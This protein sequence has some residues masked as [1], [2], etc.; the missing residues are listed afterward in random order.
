MLK[1]VVRTTMD[2]DRNTIKFKLRKKS[3]RFSVISVNSN[4]ISGASSQQHLNVVYRRQRER[5]QSFSW[6]SSIFLPEVKRCKFRI[7]H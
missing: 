4:I 7:F 3:K 6:P 5:V 2:N 1:H